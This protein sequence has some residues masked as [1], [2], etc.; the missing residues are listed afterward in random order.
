MSKIGVAAIRNRIEHS[1]SDFPTAAE[2]VLLIDKVNE[3]V[4]RL[5]S[6]GL[7]PVT[8][9]I[10]KK[11][12]DEWGREQI[13][14]QNYRGTTVNVSFK[15]GSLLAT[16][17]EAPKFAILMPNL[18]LEQTQDIVRFTLAEDSDYSRI[19]KGYPIR[20]TSKP[21]SPIGIEP[22]ETNAAF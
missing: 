1:R 14:Y 2:I 11:I 15:S 6:V 10:Q 16:L 19:W 18:R 3:V 7:L 5:L 8:Y 20:G 13:V 17:P 22:P 12:H 4:E 21:N 9:R